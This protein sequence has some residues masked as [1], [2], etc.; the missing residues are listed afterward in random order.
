MAQ[1]HGDLPPEG[2]PAAVREALKQPLIGKT[3]L[4]PE[5]KLTP[6]DEGSIQFALGERD[7]NLIINFGQ[8]VYWL[9]MPPQQAV[10]LAEAIIAKARVIARRRGEA[11]TVSL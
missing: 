8:P 5:G 6:T 11:L 9:G 7:G 3:G 2:L 4:F 1:H 10:G